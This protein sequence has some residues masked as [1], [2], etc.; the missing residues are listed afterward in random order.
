M[1]LELDKPVLCEDDEVRMQMGKAARE[2]ACAEF[3]YDVLVERLAPLA[4][5]DLSGIDVLPR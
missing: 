2:R 5:G 1:R 4:R 3:S